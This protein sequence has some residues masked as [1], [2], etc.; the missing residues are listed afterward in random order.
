[1]SDVEP[2][3]KTQPRSTNV[4]S[5][6]SP[7]PNEQDQRPPTKRARK[8]INCEPCR[9]SKLKCDRNRPC[10]SCVLRGTIALCY[11]DAR[12][13]ES[14]LNLRSDDQNAS[15]VDPMQEITRLKHSVSL[16]ET[17]IIANHRNLPFKRPLDPPPSGPPSPLKKEPQD[18]DSVD[19][20]NPPG[21]IGSQGHGGFYAGT[22]SVVTH[23]TMNEARASD[24]PMDRHPS[25]EGLV[26]DEIAASTHE[27][28]RDLLELLPALDTIDTLVIYY[29]EY[30]NW[31]YRH[32][33][34]PAFTA[35]WARFKSGSSPDR[36]V[37]ATVCMIMAIAVHYLPPRDPLIAHLADNHEELGKRFYDVMRTALDR[38]RAE[39]R[40]YTLELVECLLIRSHYLNLSK[41]DSEEIWAIRAELVSMGLAMGLHR[42]P[43]RWRMNKELAER[44]RWAWWHIIL[45]ERWQAFMFGRPLAVASHH[46]D[47]QLPSVSPIIPTNPPQPRLYAPNLALFRLAYVLGDIMDSAVSLRSVSYDTIMA[48]DKA[49]ANWMDNLPQEL[50]LDEFRIARALASSDIVTRRLGVQSVII[51]TSYYHIRF[52]LHRPYAS[53]SPSLFLND[54]DKH[55]KPEKDPKDAAKSERQANSLDIAVGSADKLI[56]LVD[57]ARPDFLA[58]ASL[59]V[60]G[61]MS[62]G[63][64]HVFSAA[65]FFSF[66]LISNPNQPGAGLFR[67]N[68]KKALGTLDLSRGQAVADRALDILGALQP[69]YE[70]GFADMEASERE[71]V[72]GRVLGLVKTLAFPYHDQSRSLRSGAADSPHN[73]SGGS[74]SGYMGSPPGGNSVDYPPHT[75][76]AQPRYVPPNTSPPYPYPENRG[77]S[78]V[79]GSYE[80]ARYVDGASRTVPA[81]GS[82]ASTTASTYPDP[83]PPA[84]ARNPY[85]PSGSGS[86]SGSASGSGNPYPAPPPPVPTQPYSDSVRSYPPTSDGT[87]VQ[88][89]YPDTRPYPVQ[90]SIGG[91]RSSYP[92]TYPTPV[93]E[94]SMW[95]ASLSQAEW[96]R[97]LDV[98]QRP[99]GERG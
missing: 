44:K 71:S 92:F 49:L 27:Y 7:P 52:T 34:Q 99:T 13:H 73:Y 38:H 42:D 61:H 2:R 87:H 50:D 66:Q 9:N 95:G 64:F 82:A 67:A 93:E 39:S 90:G 72:K 24:D 12:G 18:S 68:I 84:P 58:N 56:T 15:R 31:I 43:S 47:T 22:T 5:R 54:K 4:R 76:T 20:D 40:T 89:P 74:P 70:V 78:D 45:L 81:S 53:A 80:G 79:R 85:P 60:P 30:C 17:F 25:Q 6:T 26:N 96:A 51:R 94:D 29:F 28:D 62:W 16:L 3:S 11:Q 21:M 55:D 1:M 69:L 97:F 77:Y 88:A 91:S 48:H 83:P 33:N 36:V 14:D 41:T 32:V 19:R 57:H 23:L 35:A 59:A 37:L 86:A 8:A 75:H 46:F 10:S 98:M 65:M 63:P